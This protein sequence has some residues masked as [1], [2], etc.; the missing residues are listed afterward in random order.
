[1]SRV[2]YTIYIYIHTWSF[3]FRITLNK[4]TIISN[5]RHGMFPKVTYIAYNLKQSC[6]K[7]RTRPAETYTRATTVAREI[8]SCGLNL[9]TNSMPQK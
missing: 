6:R 3:I 1:M 7:E 9:N 5:S 8:I 2:T 4:N